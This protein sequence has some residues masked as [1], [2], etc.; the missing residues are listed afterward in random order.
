MQET[1]EWLKVSEIK[2]D[3]ENQVLVMI[4]G[5][6]IADTASY[7]YIA[8]AIDDREWSPP[9]NAEIEFWAEMPRR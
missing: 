8:D 2:P 5:R 4:K 1:I 3:H 9:F 7:D 6:N